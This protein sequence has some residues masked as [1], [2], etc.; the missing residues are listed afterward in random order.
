VAA[1]AALESLLSAAVADGMGVNHRHQP[2]R[3]LFGQGI[4]NLAAPLFGGVPATG[5]I[6]RSAV[7]V[8]SGAASR[9]AALTHTALL[10]LI[11][12]AA[13]PLVGRI[14]LA[15]LAGVLLLTAIRMVEVRS[16]RAMARSTRPD[17]VV[18]LLTAAATLALD[19]VKAVILGLVVAGALALRAI[20]KSARLHETPLHSDLPGD[21]TAEER[22]LLTEHIAPTASKV[23]CCSPR[24]GSYSSCRRSRTSRWSSCGCPG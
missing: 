18:L 11:V 16:V 2:D 12:V 3:E 14:P 7:N 22:E 1:L 19:L 8:R 13:A 24:T 23:R 17:A 20:A 10:A 5:A 21:H 6:A 15:V 9:L 4:A